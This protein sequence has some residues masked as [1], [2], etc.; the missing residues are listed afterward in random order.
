METRKQIKIPNLKISQSPEADS[1]AQALS[2]MTAVLDSPL[3]SQ[4][5]VRQWFLAMEKQSRP[6][7]MQY[8]AL[9]FL[10]KQKAFDHIDL[11][12]ADARLES[13]L[14][15]AYRQ[16]TGSAAQLKDLDRPLASRI[17]KK[18]SRDE[19]LYHQSIFHEGVLSLRDSLNTVWQDYIPRWRDL[20]FLA[21]FGLLLGTSSLFQEM[22][23]GLLVGYIFSSIMEYLVHIFIGHATPAIRAKLAKCGPIGRDMLN[24]W[25]EHSIHH[26]SVAQNYI[27]IFAPTKL[28]NPQ[29][30]QRQMQN[31]LKVDG[32][33]FQKGGAPLLKM[34]HN[35]NY[36]LSSSNI[37]R[38]HAF[39]FPISILAA[40]LSA[41][42]AASLG[43]STGI[44]FY[45]GFLLISQLWITTS[46]S[47]HPCLHMSA[48]KVATHA[49]WFWR[50]FLKTRI[51]RFVALSHRMHHVLGGRV[52]QN[53]NVG[54]D[55]IKGWAPITF[56]ELHELKKRNVIC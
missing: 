14:F 28:Q 37:W 34:I 40:V 36:G 27:E 53:L 43:A 46:S 38:T 22:M 16:I 20:I 19:A 54:F 33:V 45:L 6:N 2:I 26:G 21:S 24:F 31:R 5:Q 29:D 15:K 13:L 52:N 48:E 10:R 56:P 17:L 18:A 51:S 25:L 39:F 23:I 44:L 32:F 35:S 55:F 3:S 41:I 11:K 9:V 30:F 1:S 47:Y 49:P 7:L 12:D 8:T 50:L 4:P 42:A